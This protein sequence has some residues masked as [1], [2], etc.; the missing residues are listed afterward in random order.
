MAAMQVVSPLLILLY[1]LVLLFLYEE[2]SLC[3]RQFRGGCHD[4]YLRVIS[5]RIWDRTG[6][7]R[8]LKLAMLTCSQLILRTRAT[9]ISFTWLVVWTW[10][11]GPLFVLI[12]TNFPRFD[13]LLPS[14][15]TS[16]VS[17]IFLTG[18]SVPALADCNYLEFQ[19]GPLEETLETSNYQ[20]SGLEP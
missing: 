18:R 11:I 10:V 14:L 4:G 1:P 15:P 19:V 2:T 5:L 17:H 6:N 8:L 12:M 13:R 16:L 20:I 9:G 3:Y 7:Q